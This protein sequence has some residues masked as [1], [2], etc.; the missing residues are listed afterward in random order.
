M[1]ALE[2][3]V[4]SY[5][6]DARVKCPDC[7]DQRKK[8]NQK[9]FSITIKPDSNLYHCHHCGLSGAV[10]RKKFY[11]AHMEKIVKIPTQLN[12]NVQLIQD[13]FGARNVHLPE[14]AQKIYRT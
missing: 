12:Y 14:S 1:D 7:G 8:K 2:D 3:Y 13:F 11:E 5:N 4:L 9:T 10:R 6:T